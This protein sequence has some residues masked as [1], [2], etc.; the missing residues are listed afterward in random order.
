MHELSSPAQT[1]GSWV[2][3]PLEAWMC[4][5]LFYLSVVLCVGSGLATGWSSSKESYRLCIGLRNWKRGQGPT[6]GRRAIII[7][8]IIIIPQNLLVIEAFV[9]QMGH[10]YSATIFAS[11]CNHF[12]LCCIYS[13]NFYIFMNST[14]DC[15]FVALIPNYMKW[16]RNN[17]SSSLSIHIL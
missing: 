3:I 13:C 11:A 16:K 17:I 7:I 2:R 5:R 6:K 4:M 15:R 10:I 8:I 9:L 1:L 12:Y 14:T